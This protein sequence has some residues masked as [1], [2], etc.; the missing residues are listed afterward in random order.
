M[1]PI[2][3]NIVPLITASEPA[4]KDALDVVLIEDL[5]AVFAAI[6]LPTLVAITPV[7]EAMVVLTWDEA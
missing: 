3:P 2:A 1:P 6:L 7:F 4:S 5:A